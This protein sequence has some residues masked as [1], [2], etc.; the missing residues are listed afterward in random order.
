MQNQETVLMHYGIKGQK[1]GVRRFQDE[2]GSL[3]AA[4]RE[5]YQRDSVPKAGRKPKSKLATIGAAIK[6][7][8]EDK[9]DDVRKRNPKNLTDD[10]LNERI[11]RL[12]KEAEY[13]RLT[14]ELNRKPNQNQNQNNQN[15]GQGKKNKGGGKGGGKK[16]PYL[17]LALLTPVATAIGLGTSAIAKEKI[18]SFMNNHAD[19]LASRAQDAQRNIRNVTDMNYAQR[20]LDSAANARNLADAVTNAMKKGGK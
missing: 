4:G 16:H 17:A 3:T 15:Q 14:E 8:A 18:M 5:R 12:R 13:K 9:I 19:V 6:N 10:E 11:N 2:D 20:L 1:W 7:K